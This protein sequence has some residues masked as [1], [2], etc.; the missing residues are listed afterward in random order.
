MIVLGFSG[1][2]NG[3]Y[4]LRKY[5]LRFVGHVRE[6]ARDR[7]PAVVHFGTCRVQTVSSRD[8]PLFHRLLSEFGS[9]TGVPVL[10]NTSFND[11]DEPIV[12][13]PEDAVGSFLRMELDAMF[14]G[15]FVVERRGV[16]A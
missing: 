2:G 1:I 16:D 13:S 15:P 14:M 9:R 11:A 8:D 7:I 5:G 4:Y 12:C 6:A 10:M 3:E